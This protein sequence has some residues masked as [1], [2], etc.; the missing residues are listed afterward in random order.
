MPCSGRTSAASNSGSPIGPLRTASDALQAAS[1]SSGSESPVSRIACA[2]NACSSS[3]RSG[4]DLLESAKRLPHHLGADPVAREAPL[5]SREHAEPLQNRS[6]SASIPIGSR[7]ASTGPG[8]FSPSPVT[9][10][11][12]RSSAPSSPSSTARRRAPRETPAA[13]SPKIA[14]ALGEEPHVRAHLVLRDGIDRASGPAG[15][16]DG[17]VPVGRVPDRQRARNGCGPHRHDLLTRGECGCDRRAAFGLAAE[18]ARRGLRPRGRPAAAG[19]SPRRS[20]SR[21]SPRRWARRRRQARPSRAAR[22]SRTRRS[23]I[24]RRS[25]SAGSR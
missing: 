25:T 1:V 9:T 20:S 7:R 23:S 3:S 5:P 11:T 2:P 19:R 15:G 10:S 22:R 24:P 17:L 18:E 16:G 13:V 12:T 21:G 8:V 14:C 4:A 6:A